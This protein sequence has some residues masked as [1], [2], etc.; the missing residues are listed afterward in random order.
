MKDTLTTEAIIEI[1]EEDVTS[2]S[3]Y[4]EAVCENVTDGTECHDEVFI[5]CGDV[6][7]KLGNVLG[8]NPTFELDWEDP[9][10]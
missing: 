9:R 10:E 8:N 5:Q 3:L 2:L 6:E 1:D 7:T 4:T